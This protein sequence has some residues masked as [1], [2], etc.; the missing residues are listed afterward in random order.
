MQ[1]QPLVSIIINNYNY[2]QFLP[3]AIESALNQTYS[4]TEV[5]VVDDGST[6]KSQDII[7]SYYNKIIPIL[8]ENGGQASAF[9]A[10][11]AKSYGEIICMLDADDMFLPDKVTEIVKIYKQYPDI[12]WC[13][14][15][16][17]VMNPETGK[18]FKVSRPSAF[19]N[20]D[21]RDYI[22]NGQ[23]SFVHPATSGI[24]Y[25]RSLLGLILPMPEEP[26]LSD[27][28]IKLATY[29]LS[30]GFY[31]DKDLAI[32]RIHGDNAYTFRF[33]KLPYRARLDVVT[34]YWLKQK[35]PELSKFTNKVF[36]DGI[37]T[38]WRCGGVEQDYQKLVKSYWSSISPL[39]GLEILVRCLN[40][41][42]KKQYN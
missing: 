37:S 1:E 16:L 2:G 39:E 29:Y 31:M 40:R 23:R 32:Q 20:L 19:G 24:T 14:H 41:I 34:A 28:Y 35:F 22:K 17:K 7:A 6:D 25:R 26:P 21:Y 8:Q 12:G 36:A 11:F 4:N 33:D 5:I 3:A 30:P 18:T 27:N 42:V 9:N 15:T 13:F 38:Y 10:G